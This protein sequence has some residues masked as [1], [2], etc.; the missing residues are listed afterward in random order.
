MSVVGSVAFSPDGAH[1]VSGSL[2]ET[3]RLWDARTGDEL[4]RLEGHTWVVTSVA[5]SPNGGQVV[6][7]SWDKSVRLWDVRTGTELCRFDGHTDIVT[8][9]AFSRDGGQVISGS[10]D[11]TVRLWDAR[12]GV[13]LRRREPHTS[14]MN[15][16]TFWPDGPLAVFQ[17]YDT[18]TGVNSLSF[19]PDGGQVV[20]GSNDKTVRIWDPLTG[21][22]LRRFEA[23]TNGV[24]GVAFSPNGGQVVSGN[25]RSDSY[26]DTLR[27]W[28]ARTGAE[29][30]RMKRRTSG[31]TTVAFS[32]DGGQVVSGSG[33]GTIRF[34]DTREGSEV[35][36]GA[37]KA[38]WLRRLW[39]ALTRARWRRLVGHTCGVNSVSYSPHGGQVVSGGYDKTVRLWDVRTG[40]ELRQ[41]EGHEHVGKRPVSSM[42]FV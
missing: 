26:D 12:T 22:E 27:L 7:G 18:L 33:D 35:P 34:W 3:V 17:W 4:Q 8:R 6:S 10:K 15:R 38:G 14:R 9:V 41:L 29:L 13:E 1:I 5:F 42:L 32:P 39:N 16:S 23:H 28:D 36:W 37:Q 20:S 31:V 40:T 2:D 25:N 19:S 21:V 24:N 11:K 30:R